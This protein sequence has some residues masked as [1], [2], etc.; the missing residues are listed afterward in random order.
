MTITVKGLSPKESKTGSSMKPQYSGIS[1]H[2]P[3][4]DVRSY[5]E[6]LRT[7]LQPGSRASHSASWAQERVK[8]ASQ[9]FGPKRFQ[10]FASLDLHTASWKTQQISLITNTLEPYLATW[11][12]A[13]IMLGGA[14]YQQPSWA[15]PISE[16]ER[17]LWHTPTAND[18]KPA[19]M[20]EFQKAKEWLAGGQVK[21]TY[22]RL[23]SIAA[24]VE[25]IRNPLNPEWTESFLMMCPIGWTDLKP[26]AMDKFH[27]WLQLHGR[28]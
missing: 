12:K 28:S 7:S 8:K 20:S 16:I 17:G 23:R 24:A 10:P 13:A 14:C 15:L 9:T 2:S 25:G 26:L 4:A 1:E 3:I 18:F 19:G 6:G 5:I 11:P 21:N 27:K 22:I